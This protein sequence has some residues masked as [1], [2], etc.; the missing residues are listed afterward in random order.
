LPADL[1]LAKGRLALARESHPAELAAAHEDV[2]RLAPGDA[3]ASM[4]LARIRFQQGDYAAAEK[5]FRIACKD[6]KDSR[7]W[8]EYGRSLLELKRIDEA[9]TALQKAVDLGD[10]DAGL[11]LD[12]ARIRMDKGDLDWAEALVKDLAKKSPVDP[13]PQYWLGQIALKRQQTAVAEEFFRKSHQLRP[14]NGVYSEALARQLR[15]K[16][17]W[18]PAAAVLAQ[19][20]AKLTPSGKLLYGDCLAHSGE[21]SKALEVYG[22]LYQQKASAPLLSRRMDLM[23]K[24]GKAG[25]AVEAAGGSP[26]QDAVDVKYSLAKAQLSLAESHV[27]KGDVDQAVDLMKSVIKGDFRKPEYHYHLGLA[28]ALQNKPKKALS[29]FTDAITYRVDYPD[30][31]YRKGI[32][33]VQL[34]EIKDAANSFSELSQHADPAWKA[35]GLY[36]LASVFAAEGKPEAVQHHLERSIA[37][38]PT[39]DAMAHLSRVLVGQGKAAEAQEWARKAITLDPGHE[40]ATVAMA[41]ALAAG[42]KQGEAMELARQGLKV[43]PLSCGLLVQSAKLNYQAGK[44]DSTLA[45]SNVAIK[46]CPEDPMAYF[47]AGVATHSS[48]R[49]K[50]AKQYFKAYR[51]YGG[52]EKLVPAK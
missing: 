10:K 29:A 33:L 7:A 16:D 24:M 38:A 47:Y 28:Y 4:G 3:D 11:R 17:E 37:V 43:R 44:M 39:A 42:K 9:A 36:G 13:E 51:K 8:A 50:E 27:L 35:R 21:Q 18:K 49:P 52:D 34:G 14:D 20:E 32:S 46:A 15:D 30:A 22:A 41:D 25:Q 5:H 12:L 26:F 40:A 45:A 1:E 31:L 6:S 19:S 23:V 48:N 2:L